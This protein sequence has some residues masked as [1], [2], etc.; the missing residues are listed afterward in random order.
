MKNN[1]LVLKVSGYHSTG[2]TTVTTRIYNL[3][4]KNR[5]K[6]LDKAD[7]GTIGQDF[8]YLLE[9]KDNNDEKI[10]IIIN[11]AS[12]RNCDIGNLEDF[13][14]IHDFDILVTAIRDFDVERITMQKVIDKYAG[15]K[16]FQLEFPLAKISGNRKNYTGICNL[17]LN[18]ATELAKHILHNNPYG[19]KI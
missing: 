10:L 9:G 16:S 4:I 7:T 8:I 12:D 11:T 1:K 3:L 17:F 14:K 2:K 15:K 6:E 5:Y 19:L 18:N 13:L